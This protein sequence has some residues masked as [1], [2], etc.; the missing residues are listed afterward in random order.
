[1]NSGFPLAGKWLMFLRYRK[2]NRVRSEERLE[3]N[4]A[5]ACVSKVAEEFVVTEYG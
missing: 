4:F 5:N 3:T 1:V 2:Q